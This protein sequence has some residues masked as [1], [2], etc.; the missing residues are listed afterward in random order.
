[1]PLASINLSHVHVK[2]TKAWVQVTAGVDV[3]GGGFV[4]MAA[5]PGHVLKHLALLQV[6][7]RAPPVPMS[8][9]FVRDLERKR[10]GVGK[11]QG[12][13]VLNPGG[14]GHQKKGERKKGRRE[15]RRRGNRRR[16]GRRKRA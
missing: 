1:M 11:G 5:T 6:Q 12:Q 7:I 10:E 15:R 13:K 14:Q 4:V 16:K 8:P 2:R 3:T 9:K